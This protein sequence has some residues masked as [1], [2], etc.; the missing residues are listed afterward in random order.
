MHKLFQLVLL[1]LLFICNASI[2]DVIVRMEIQQGVATD[3]VDFRLYDDVAPVTVENFLNYVNGGDY[4]KSFIHRSVPGFVVQG[5]GFTFDPAVNDG[6]FT[7]N[8]LINDYPGG[9]QP[10]PTDLP[11]INE[12]GRSNLRG[13]VSMAKLSGDADSA[14]SQWFIN[15]ADNSAS[16]DITNGGYTVFGDVLNNGM[17]VIDSIASQPVYP[18]TDIHTAFGELPL[19]NFSSDPIQGNNLIMINRVTELFTVSPDI[20][21]G[22]VTS[23][24]DVQPEIT[25]TNSGN[26]AIQIGGIGDVNPVADPFNIVD[27]RCANSI[28]KPGDQ[29]SFMVLFSPDA[30]GTYVDSFN[31]EIVN[32]GISYRVSLRGDG[33]PAED[34]P[35]ILVSFTSVDYGVVDVL[36]G[37]AAAPYVF[38]QIVQNS[39]RL[40]LTLASIDV[41]GQ[42]AADINVSGS[43]IGLVALAP[44]KFCSFSIEFKPLTSGEKYAEISISSNDPDENPFIIPIRGTA[45][46]ED[47]GVPASIEDAGPNN[48]DGN[49]DDVLD[50]KQSNVATF[51]DTYGHYVTFLAQGVF[52][53]SGMSSLLE[54]DLATMPADA[55][56]GSGIFNFTVED[57]IPGQ[58][59]EIGIILPVNAVPSAYYMYGPTADNPDPHWYRFDFDGETGA[60]ILN[61]VTFTTSSGAT[62][63]RNVLKVFHKDGGRGDADMTEN[64]VIAVTSG[65]PVGAMSDEGSGS[66][67]FL[68]LLSIAVLL[69]AARGYSKSRIICK[70]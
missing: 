61:S 46:G 51:I 30:V 6:T 11:I 49:N 10:V 58:A 12:F 38:S 41:T 22:T 66:I 13:T 60:I 52:R 40:D 28:I 68:L 64:G 48:G 54:S 29:C 35:D 3:N 27:G 37:A 69:V 59:L 39:G 17:T 16:L 4:D 9:L 33:G 32:Y 8:P 47:D 65:M 5:G 24:S 23:G 20:D 18:R 44:G 26:D 34:E 50:S 53:F 1:A 15:L 63:T 62:F 36:D 43:C 55:I 7:N 45:A 14:T 21:Y 31:I 57:M 19:D 25:I 42:D 56:I 2:A 67:S 70:K